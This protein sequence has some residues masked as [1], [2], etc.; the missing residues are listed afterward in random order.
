MAW[1]IHAEKIFALGH[2]I[3]TFNISKDRCRLVL[4]G[5]ILTRVQAVNKISLPYF[6]YYC[7]FCNTETGPKHIRIYD[8]TVKYRPGPSDTTVEYC[9]CDH[10]HHSTLLLRDIRAKVATG[11]VALTDSLKLSSSK[12]VSNV[13]LN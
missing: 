13:R 11:P 8:A 5:H 1:N 4:L 12:P 3:S 9:Y 10:L 6:F 2:N 7:L